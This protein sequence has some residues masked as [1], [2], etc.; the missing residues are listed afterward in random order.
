M[1]L[2]DQNTFLIG[3]GFIIFLIVL[4]SAGIQMAIRRSAR[5]RKQIEQGRSQD[6]AARVAIG[7]AK[8]SEAV[9]EAI[10]REPELANASSPEELARLDELIVSIQKEWQLKRELQAARTA[11]RTK[12]IQKEKA[13]LDLEKAEA[14]RL[15]REAHKQRVSEKYASRP[16]RRLIA[17]HPW[18]STV[19]GIGLAGLVAALG[20][21]VAVPGLV[22]FL[23]QQQIQAAREEA[24]ESCDPMN[25]A[26]DLFRKEPEVVEAWSQCPEASARAA[27][28]R[29]VAGMPE[30]L[31]V[32]AR[33]PDSE[34]RIAVA[35]RPG[36][37]KDLV[38][39]L[40]Q[41]AD[42]SVTNAVLT[43]TRPDSCTG[44]TLFFDRVTNQRWK[45]DERSTDVDEPARPMEII[46][47]SDCLLNVSGA[48]GFIRTSWDQDSDLVTFRIGNRF[49]EGS[50]LAGSI[51]GSWV[52]QRTAISGQNA[53]E[54]SAR[55]G[56]S[57]EFSLSLDQ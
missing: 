30:I 4:T 21:F 52:D 13:R 39:L 24:I 10:K 25:E 7:Q 3:F 36:L 11:E 14:E 9:A 15:A 57:G 28:A 5:E 33:D 49:F 1:L 46:F 23:E 56:R 17:L 20:W 16:L 51:A 31:E 2:I 37:P 35:Q 55:Q 29:L 22:G 27:A 45:G 41:D 6:Q 44:R 38:R 43:N 12:E 54:G 53:L 32:L 42:P 19:L 48:T 34:V 47:R 8:R 50:L 18:Q 40:E 26:Y